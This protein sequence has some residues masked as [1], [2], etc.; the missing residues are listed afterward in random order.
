M[1]TYKEILNCLLSFKYFTNSIL[2][3]GKI[4]SRN[5]SITRQKKEY[6]SFIYGSDYFG[7]GIEQNA[8]KCNRIADWTPRN[9]M[10]LSGHQ[11]MN[12]DGDHMSLI[13][14]DCP[15]RA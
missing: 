1:N 13:I 6:S 15:L 7:G 11:L 4:F 3:S 2:F 5:M 9:G 8:N 14:I 10:C 12:C